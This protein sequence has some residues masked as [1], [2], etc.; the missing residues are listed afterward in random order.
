MNFI[1]LIYCPVFAVIVLFSVEFS[2]AAD[3]LPPDGKQY[4]IVTVCVAN[5]RE[6]PRHAAEMATQCLLG[7]PL[8]VREKRSGWCAVTT[9]EGYDCWVTADSI[10]NMTK[11]EFNQWIEAPKIIYQKNYGTVRVESADD[12]A[13]VSD[14]TAGCV[15]VQED[16]SGR[17]VKLRF[18]DGRSG[19]IF[20]DDC[21]DFETWKRETKPTADGVLEKALELMGVAYLW[22]G[23]SPKMLDCSGLTKHCFFMN[24]VIIPR[25]ASQQAQI[26]LRIDIDGGL[27]RLQK[28][29]LLFFGSSNR[30]THVGIYIEEG[31]FVHEAGRVRLNN[32]IPG[33]ELYDKSSAAGLV[34]ACRLIGVPE[35][36]GIISIADHP[37]YRFQAE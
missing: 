30:I 21:S 32:L 4:A 8:R 34:R 7:T 25:N 29:D 10:V 31:R 33:K 9:P 22:G 36:S 1:R 11:S 3:A 27:D 37:L 17:Y 2:A 35:K 18:P 5:M 20:R 24:G 28:G 12:S 19:W 15:A 23:T 14:I 13:A 26:G 6:K 16:V